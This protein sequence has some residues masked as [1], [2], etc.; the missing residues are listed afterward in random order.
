MLGVSLCWPE[1]GPGFNPGA[2]VDLG[3]LIARADPNVLVV[4]VGVF[5][6]LDDH[7]PDAAEEREGEADHEAP[8]LPELGEAHAPGHGEGAGD[9]HA[10]V[11]RAPEQVEV[12]VGVFET[13]G[14]LWR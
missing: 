3:V 2:V 11:E 13:S 10:G 8:R 5:D 14:W 6:G 1:V 9:E 7:E 4:L 12:A